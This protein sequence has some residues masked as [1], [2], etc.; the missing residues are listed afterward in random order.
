MTSFD[1]ESNFRDEALREK[2][3]LNAKN[4]FSSSP[5]P[6]PIFIFFRMKRI[7]I[8]QIIFGS[9]TFFCRD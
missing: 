3:H 7:R 5:F 4:C 1:R 6:S 2:W 8:K 9:E